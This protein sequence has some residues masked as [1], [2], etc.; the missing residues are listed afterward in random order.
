MATD[1]DHHSPG[2]SEKSS[3]RHKH[4]HRHGS[5]NRDEESE[6]VGETVPAVPSPTHAPNSAL[7]RAV[8]SDD[9]IEEGEIVE[10]EEDGEIG[11]MQIDAEPGEI[12]V[13]GDRDV[14]SD[15]VN[16]VF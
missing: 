9:D 10:E 3:K 15:E 4:R 1:D 14:Q 5:R 7:N 11:K 8:R 2:D 12:E 13:N 16:L 6:H